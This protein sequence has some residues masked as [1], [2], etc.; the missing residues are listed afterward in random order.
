MVDDAAQQAAQQAANRLLNE[1]IL[2]LPK[3]YS[4][5]ED[6]VTAKNL[7]STCSYLDSIHGL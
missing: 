6:T 5:A 1:T 4:T 3:F 7:I 2:D